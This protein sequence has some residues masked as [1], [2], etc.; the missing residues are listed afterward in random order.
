MIS[1]CERGQ[2]TACRLGPRTPHFSSSQIASQTGDFDH[3]ENPDS[4]E[5]PAAATVAGGDAVSPVR[6]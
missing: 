1:A 6:G 2:M 4:I 3:P 5:S